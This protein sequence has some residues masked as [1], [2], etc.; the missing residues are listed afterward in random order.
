MDA[1]QFFQNSAGEWRSQRSTHHL[2]FRQAE[3]GD[4]NIQVTALGA[5]DARVAEI[6]QMHEV[7][8]SRAAGGAF[9]TWHG[10]MAWD[11][12]EENHQGSTVFAIVPDPENPRQGLMLRERGYAETAPVAGRFEMDDDDALLLITEYE[13]M[14]SIERFWFPNPNVRMRT[15]TVKRFGGPST[16]TFCTEIR[17]QPDADAASE[18]AEKEPVASEF[19]SALGW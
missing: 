5:D 4:S 10:T 1:M 8:P 12:D 18:A 13:T 16:A 15:S 17:V 19:Y 6:C 3:I 2:A 14:S 11:K 9:V 7:E